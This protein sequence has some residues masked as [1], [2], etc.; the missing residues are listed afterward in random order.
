LIKNNFKKT[1]IITISL[2]SVLLVLMIFSLMIG[3][4]KIGFGDIV[5]TLIHGKDK[6]IIS[7]I[8]LDVRLPRILLAV[9][10]GASLSFSGGIFQAL[11][12]NPLADPYI[13]GISGGAAVGSLLAMV[14]GLDIWYFAIPIF[15]FAG[16]VTVVGVVYWLSMRFGRIDANTMLLTGVMVSAFLSAIIL[17]L[18]TMLGNTVRNAL[19]WLLGN[20]SNAKLDQVLYIYPVVL[21]LSF[22]MYYHSNKLNLIAMGDEFAS[23]LGINV[24]LIKKISYVIASIVTGLVVSLSGTIGFIGLIIPHICRMLIGPD[25]RVLLPVSFF[26][27][28]IFL[29][30]IDTLSRLL[31]DPI[32]LPIG[33]LTAAV[34]A[35]VFIF[36]LRRH[37]L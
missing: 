9:I 32:E 19:I 1:L 2:F 17:F 27:G 23:Q 20:L 15:A 4:Y 11:L 34:G 10:V 35:P 29:L 37:N 30:L 3:S 24:N 6:D 26:S 28:G 22:F 13:L 31:F 18:V 21:L 7:G 8:I 5:N 12:R 14:L 33:A 25:Y 36:I 16:S